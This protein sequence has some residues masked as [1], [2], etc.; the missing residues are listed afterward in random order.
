[1]FVSGLYSLQT[2]II[3]MLLYGALLDVFPISYVID[4]RNDSWVLHSEPQIMLMAQNQNKNN[5]NNKNSY[6]CFYCDLLFRWK[7]GGYAWKKVGNVF[8]HGLK[9]KYIIP[10]FFSFSSPLSTTCFAFGCLKIYLLHNTSSVV[11]PHHA[12]GCV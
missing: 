1:M 3:V 2:S 12:L 4:C 7:N 8:V 9:C 10:I 5:N 11:R 6:Y